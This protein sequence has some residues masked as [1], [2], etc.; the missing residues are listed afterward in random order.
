MPCFKWDCGT[1]SKKILIKIRKSTNGGDWSCP[2]SGVHCFLWNSL[3]VFSWSP[4]LGFCI[5]IASTKIVRS[6]L[7]QYKGSQSR[8]S[9]RR[10]LSYCTGKPTPERKSHLSWNKQ[11]PKESWSSFLKLLLIPE[12]KRDPKY[13]LTWRLALSPTLRA[14]L[15]HVTETQE[16]L[17]TPTWLQERWQMSR[18]GQALQTPFM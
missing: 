9:G 10:G 11:R 8:H 7:K 12:K 17:H 18:S 1:D 3:V 16:S 14:T 13:P 5:G 2:S 6:P 15:G 4:S